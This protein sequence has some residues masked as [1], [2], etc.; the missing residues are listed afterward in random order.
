VTMRTDAARPKNRRAYERTIRDNFGAADIA[1]LAGLVAN[2]PDKEPD[3]IARLF[4][5][6]PDYVPMINGF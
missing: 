4:E 6:G 1:R 3:A 5:A 2:H